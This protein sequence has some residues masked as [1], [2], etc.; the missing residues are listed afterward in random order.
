MN[1]VDLVKSQ[2]GG[3]VLGRL[4][5]L[6]GGSEAQTRGASDAAV[7]AML[8][9]FAKLAGT[10][11][12]GDLLSSIM[13]KIDLST[14]GNLAGTLAG[15]GGS[16]MGS[17]GGTILTTLLGNNLGGIVS[18]IAK[19]AGA[20][21]ELMKKLL[22]YLGPIVLGVI[23]KQ[24]G[25]RPDAA[26][27][28]R[29]FAD[30][31]GNIES[32]LPQGLSLAGFDPS[33]A[34]SAASKLLP[35][36]G[37]SRGPGSEE[38][39]GFPMWVLPALLALLGAGYWA[40]TQVGKAPEG[41]VELPRPAAVIDEVTVAKEGPVTVVEEKETLVDEKGK[42]I[43]Q[44]VEDVVAVAKPAME[45][46]LEGQIK[47]FGESAASLFDGLTKLLGEVTDEASAKTALPEIQKLAPSLDAFTKAA[48]AIPEAGRDSAMQLVTDRL[49]PIQE[50][51][52]KVMA[53][54][55]VKEVLEPVVGPML[56]TLSGLVK[57][58]AAAKPEPAAEP[59]KAG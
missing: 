16:T 11:G 19:V 51:V 36:Q 9:M 18:A 42:P 27:V 1:I 14:L 3:E 24:L 49:G 40:Y 8:E 12:G 38:A 43:A 23:A 58:V 22:T 54:P 45:A 48:G 7:P 20:Q 53:I 34:I 26:G 10:K 15:G 52:A 33:A 44:V 5:G 28:S 35:A 6:V 37:G 55:G 41:G 59:E 32:A 50:L 29:L 47:K 57:P 46:A 2:L 4:G 39:A 56:E 13:G 21:P 30:Q 17:L 31:K 25:G